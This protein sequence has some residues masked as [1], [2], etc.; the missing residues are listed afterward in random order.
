MYLNGRLVESKATNFTFSNQSA[1][2]MFVGG[3]AG[4]MSGGASD[5]GSDHFQGA[6]HSIAEYS[7][8]FSIDDRQRVEGILCWQF[9]TQNTLPVGHPYR[10]SP[11]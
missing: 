8:I 2:Q 11:P 7:S 3:A 9:G 6:I 1:R 4:T 10:N 5:C